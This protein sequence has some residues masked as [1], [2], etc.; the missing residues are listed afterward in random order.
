M[1]HII[2]KFNDI[3]VPFLKINNCTNVFLE[4]KTNHYPILK[5]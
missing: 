4:T 1:Q 2:L 3:T 5:K